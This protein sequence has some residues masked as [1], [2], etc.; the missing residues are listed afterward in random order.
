MNLFFPPLSVNAA[1]RK[2][3]VLYYRTLA[4][5]KKVLPC[6][7]KFCLEKENFAVGKTIF[8]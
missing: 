3:V 2:T 6:D 4:T 8:P 5:R 1:L 7:R